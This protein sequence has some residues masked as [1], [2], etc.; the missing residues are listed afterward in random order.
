MRRMARV[1][2]VAPLVL[3]LFGCRSDSDTPHTTAAESR[4]PIND[5]TLCQL[6]PNAPYGQTVGIPGTQ[7]MVASADIHASL[8]GCKVLARGG[9][10][11]DA[12]VAV[13]AVLGVAEPFA[14]GLAGGSVITYYDAESRRVRVFDGIAAA[15]SIIG[16]ATSL[17][18]VAGPDDINCRPNIT[19]ESNVSSQQ[20][21]VNI[22]GRA[23]AVPGTVKVLDMVHQAY[24]QL[25][26][27]DLWDDAIQLARDGFPMT[28]Y[29]YSTLYSNG[30]VFDDET[31]EPL[32]AGGIPAWFNSARTH[33]GAVRCRFKDIKARYC[34]PAD[35]KS[36]KPLPIGTLITNN[37][38]AATMELIRDGGA[39][40]FYDTEGPIAEAILQRFHE[41]KYKADGTNN[42][43]SALPTTASYA[44]GTAKP[45]PA[46][47]PSLMTQSDFGIYRAFE[48]TPLVGNRFGL[49]IHS[50]PPPLSGGFV[51]LQVLGMLERKG[52]ESRDFGSLEFI[53]LAA[54]ASRLATQDRRNLVGDPAF[55]NTNERVGEAL[56]PSYLD[57][58][59]ALINGTAIDQVP[60]GDASNGI[61]EFIALDPWFVFN[62]A[63]L[64]APA[65]KSG[66]ARSTQSSTLLPLVD[67]G[68]DISTTSNIAIIDR[69]GNALSMTTTINTHW[70][71][72]IEAAGMLLNNGMSNFSAG[73]LGSDVN[74]YAG[75]KRPRS[76]IG[77]SIAFDDEGRVRLVWG[78]AGGGPIPDYIVK[79]FL[80]H[81]VYG[82][83]IQAAI[84]TDNWTGQTF[85][86]TNSVARVERN[87]PIAG[88]VDLMRSTY[89]YTEANMDHIGLTS[90]LTGISVE[91]DVQGLPTYRGAADYR[92]AGGA[93]GY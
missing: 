34:D 16:D 3:G 1:W 66:E 42:C 48:R 73:S 52:I 56:L 36:E 33:W 88:T 92:R 59:T 29:M 7:V 14:S 2:L 27:S 77:P 70:G 18:D 49:T 80:G 86:S 79:T 91:Y 35:P 24:G 87:K 67:D 22:S 69:Q 41:D 8:A 25:P 43:Y 13:Q 44:A 19:A 76:S 21:N 10:A 93:A 9:S 57:T 26:W 68:D 40:A 51:I 85:L 55:S 23:V 4:M 17:Y 38:L 84:N 31:G 83:D 60:L 47:I 82:M 46:R 39:E 89:G 32:N 90:G 72:H 75:N 62:E 45:T 12:A 78:S 28:K 65:K 50:A 15:P 63:E 64:T 61:S 30:T 81:V 58:R 54:E 37:E 74:G 20:G 6:Q 11:I 71:A 53:Y 5:D